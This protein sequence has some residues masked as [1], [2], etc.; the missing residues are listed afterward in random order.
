MITFYKM[1][2]YIIDLNNYRYENGPKSAF[3]KDHRD[4]FSKAINML[5]NYSTINQTNLLILSNKLR[6]DTDLTANT[7]Q[8]RLMQEFMFH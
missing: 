6:I 4:L 8:N 5:Q 7:L 1:G 3:F 2:D